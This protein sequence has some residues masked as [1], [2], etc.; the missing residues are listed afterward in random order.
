MQEVQIVLDVKISYKNSSS[1]LY[2]GIF[3]KRLEL[4]FGKKLHSVF[5]YKNVNTLVGKSISR[6]SFCWRNTTF[7]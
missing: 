3:L 1:I 4:K 2:L 5:S 7:C 6:K